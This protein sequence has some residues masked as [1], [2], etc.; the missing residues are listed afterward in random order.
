MK[1]NY[2]LFVLTIFFLSSCTD[3]FYY[4]PNGHNVPLFS[5][6][7]NLQVKI[8]HY[9]IHTAY[10]ISDKFA[11]QANAYKVQIASTDNWGKGYYFDGLFGYY[12]PFNNFVFEI[13]NGLG[14]SK[15]THSYYHYDY[16][17]SWEPSGGPDN[18]FEGTSGMNFFKYYIQPDFGFKKKNFEIS[19]SVRAGMLYFYNINYTVAS[20]RT[21]FYKNLDKMKQTQNYFFLE[22]ELNL[23][24]GFR[25][26]KLGI[27]IGSSFIHPEFPYMD[28]YGHF[29]LDISV[30]QLINAF[31]QGF[32]N[33][34][35]STKY[36]RH[37]QFLL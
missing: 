2:F 9:N 27:H 34:S 14:W 18:Y 10:S 15:Q 31:K 23:K 21:T 11:V 26:I 35:L 1:K 12:K 33:V 8:N 13:Y 32:Y 4:L 25:P 24:I 17:L 20:N 22:P 5:K 7:N 29:T 6:K 28:D 36:K 16:V 30:F 37:H 3:H 19:M